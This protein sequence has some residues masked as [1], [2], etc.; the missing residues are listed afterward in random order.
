MKG[1]EIFHRWFVL[2]RNGMLEMQLSDLEFFPF[3]YKKDIAVSD[4]DLFF[5]GLDIY[6]F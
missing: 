1:F 6:R 5:Y 2:R 3:P 4:L